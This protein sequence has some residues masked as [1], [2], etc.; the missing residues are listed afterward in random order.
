MAILR[1][2]QQNQNRFPAPGLWARN[3]GN[4]WLLPAHRKAIRDFTALL[5][6]LLVFLL[7]PT[8]KTAAGTWAD[9]LF[10]ELNKDFGSVPRGALLQH[11]FR[12]VNN[13]KDVVGISGIRS[14][15]GCTTAHITKRYLQPGEEVPVQI[16]MDSGRFRGP[17]TVTLYVRIDRPEVQEVRIWVKANSRDDIGI[18]PDVLDFKQVQSGQ[19]A[20][21]KVAVRFFGMPQA[22]ITECQ[23][24]SGYLD[25]K[26]VEEKRTELETVFSLEVNL[27]K[28]A[29]VGRWYSDIWLTTNQSGTPRIR[30]PVRMEVVSNL[31]A[32]PASVEFGPVEKGKEIERKVVIRGA[33]PFRILKVE[34]GNDLVKTRF[35]SDLSKTTHVVT[36]TI[37]NEKNTPLEGNIQVSTDLE[38]S[39]VL[40]IPFRADRL[41]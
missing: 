32:S 13:T 39:P 36:F 37:K 7:F 5:V 3:G 25:A 21:G 24:A 1:G 35:S 38:S 17:K 22:E 18:T 12:V 26:V 33:N 11:N 31:V 27:K 28:M 6:A 20:F 15:C 19:G 23:P 2:K 41:P 14:S 9:G 10:D 40:S 34:T 4:Q 30:V 16:R 8:G 29:P